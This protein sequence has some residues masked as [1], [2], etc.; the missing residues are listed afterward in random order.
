MKCGCGC[1]QPV[2]GRRSNKQFVDE[3]HKVRAGYARRRE[4]RAAYQRQWWHERRALVQV[5]AWNADTQCANCF[6]LAVCRA[7]VARVNAVSVYDDQDMDTRLMKLP[8]F[9][10]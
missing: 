4:E 1:G 8:C 5:D 3:K 9:L 10:E 2:N 7:Q 6:F